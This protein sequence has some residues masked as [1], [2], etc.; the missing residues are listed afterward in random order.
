VNVRYVQFSR[1][2]K[3][4]PLVPD[5]APLSRLGAGKP[6]FSQ[7]RADPGEPGGSRVIV[8]D[9]QFAVFKQVDWQTCGYAWPM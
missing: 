9:E 4:A 8:H 6:D 2:K 3:S 7:Q 5:T 1:Q